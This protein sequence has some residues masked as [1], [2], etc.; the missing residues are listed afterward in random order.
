MTRQNQRMQFESRLQIA[1][2]GRVQNVKVFHLYISYAD[3]RSILQTTKFDISSKAR[4]ADLETLLAS[5]QTEREFSTSAVRII[6]APDL[7]TMSLYN[8]LRYEQTQ[9][10]P[11]IRF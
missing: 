7:T 11:L 4:V 1:A 10:C 2:R 8:T 9:P 6:F 3:T 5:W